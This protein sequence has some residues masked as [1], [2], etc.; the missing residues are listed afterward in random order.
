M[1]LTGS[2]SDLQIS[3]LFW[4]FCLSTEASGLGQLP[5]PYFVVAWSLSLNTDKANR[6]HH[7]PPHPTPTRAFL[8]FYLISW[9]VV[10]NA[11]LGLFA[12]LEVECYYPSGCPFLPWCW[13]VWSS[14]GEGGRWFLSCRIQGI[15]FLRWLTL[16]R[17]G[18]PGCLLQ[19]QPPIFLLW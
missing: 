1:S 4:A 18:V 13:C 11:S 12:G 5:G 16:I 8:F 9:K 7:P 19:T 2:L 17:L 14:M 10:A 3:I 15:Y 6:L